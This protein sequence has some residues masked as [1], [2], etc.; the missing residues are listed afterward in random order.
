VRIL[1]LIWGCL[2][3]SQAIVSIR[4][5]LT[6]VAQLAGSYPAATPEGKA[7]FERLVTLA[8]FKTV[9]LLKLARDVICKLPSPVQLV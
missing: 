8:E 9:V 5:A 3:E 4:R 1:T 2:S 7:R 6:Y